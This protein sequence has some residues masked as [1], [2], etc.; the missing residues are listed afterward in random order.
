MS[1]RSLKK[2]L[3]VNTHLLCLFMLRSS[4]GDKGCPS[5][6]SVFIEGAWMNL[7]LRALASDPRRLFDALLL[8]A[9]AP[10]SPAGVGITCGTTFMSKDGT[11]GTMLILSESTNNYY[12]GTTNKQS[13]A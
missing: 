9:G 1:A 13:T 7:R 3:A 10:G 2:A 8:F 12:H 5:G 6:P 11:S 4:S